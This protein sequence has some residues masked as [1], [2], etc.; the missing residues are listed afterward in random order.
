MLLRGRRMRRK[1][2]TWF[3]GGVSAAWILAAAALPGHARADGP[4]LGRAAAAAPL[5]WTAATPD[6]MV[7][8]VFARAQQGGDDALAALVVAASLDDRASFGK[9]RDGLKAIAASSSPLA[10]EARW[11]RP[12]PPPPPPDPPRPRPPP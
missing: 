11:L 4:S 6:E 7:D 10:D 9:V 3:G 5:R 1:S 8:R 12:P 2:V